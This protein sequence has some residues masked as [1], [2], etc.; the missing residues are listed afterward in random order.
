MSSSFVQSS[1]S[2]P[3]FAD[4]ANR[5][6]Q[7]QQSGAT[8][9]QT[10]GGTSTGSTSS[11]EVA[12]AFFAIDDSREK[13]H[14]EKWDLH[15]TTY[16]CYAAA[17]FWQTLKKSQELVEKLIPND[18][19]PDALQR[20]LQLLEELLAKTDPQHRFALV[21][22]S[23]EA[24]SHSIGV[25]MLSTITRT[26]TNLSID[27]AI[28]RAGDSEEP[29]SVLLP[30]LY[31]DDPSH[32]ATGFAPSHAHDD[33]RR[34][35]DE[36]FSL[37]HVPDADFGDGGVTPP[38]PEPAPIVLS[39]GGFR[40]ELD[41]GGKSWADGL[42]SPGNFRVLDEAKIEQDDQQPGTAFCVTTKE[43][44]DVYHDVPGDVSNAEY[45]V[46]LVNK[47]RSFAIQL[48]DSKLRISPVIFIPHL[49][50]VE[51]QEGVILTHIGNE[52]LQFSPK[53]GSSTPVQQVLPRTPVT[54]QRPARPQRVPE[55]P[56][57]YT[58][59]QKATRAEGASS[60]SLGNDSP[61]KY[62]PVK[63]TWKGEVYRE[64]CSTD[65]TLDFE[66]RGLFYVAVAG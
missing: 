29:V 61:V 47:Q 15:V 6:L 65:G 14:F 55:T 9:L 62:S 60:S 3:S 5:S 44:F 8:T 40:F 64:I 59:P 32:Q 50:A 26:N 30:N 1:G 24:P 36:I 13:L 53:K 23:R 45:A 4:T 7:P 10:T 18:V 48:A 33:D 43:S 22:V 37:N 31:E 38:E 66:Q 57:S 39:D 2:L 27:D 28:A 35:V 46:Y 51:G 63:S 21:V 52:Q 11:M 54:P 25:W 20:R 12:L 19:T 58:T 42:P 49:S 56:S 16:D 17:M 34:Y 41:D